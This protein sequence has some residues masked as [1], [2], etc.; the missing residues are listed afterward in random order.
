MVKLEKL[1]LQHP[2]VLVKSKKTLNKSD[3]GYFS[4]EVINSAEITETSENNKYKVGETIFVDMN[5]LTEFI[6]DGVPYE[7]IYLLN[8]TMAKGSYAII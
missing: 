6:L 3:K 8:E 2:L 7:N 5:Y 4:V 1:E